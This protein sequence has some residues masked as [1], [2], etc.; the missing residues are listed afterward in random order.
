MKS[1]TVLLFTL[2]LTYSQAQTVSNVA[3][4]PGVVG[5]ANG[6]AAASSFNNPHGVACD[7]QG[8]IYVANRVGHTIRKITPTGIGSWFA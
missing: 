7:W 4:M 1:L 2:I 3:G 8:N 6:Q 5:F